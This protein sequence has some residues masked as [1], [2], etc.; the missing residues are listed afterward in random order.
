MVTIHSMFFVVATNPDEATYLAKLA[1]GRTYATNDSKHP[2]RPEN[3]DG[4]KVVAVRSI[5]G[6]TATSLSDDWRIGQVPLTYLP[7]GK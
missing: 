2:W 4:T 1:V 5:D 6:A 3:I 7:K